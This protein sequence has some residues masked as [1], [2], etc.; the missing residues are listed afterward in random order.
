[1]TILGKRGKL[2]KT[3]GI[4]VTIVLPLIAAFGFVGSA[5]YLLSLAHADPS[6]LAAA[7]AFTVIVGGVM[8]MVFSI[9]AHAATGTGLRGLARHLVFGAQ[10]W[11]V[12]KAA[13]E[14]K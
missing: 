2:M 10:Y 6:L 12:A 14:G 7:I 3:V 1:M 11:V 8:V 9:I 4:V 5:I 13:Q